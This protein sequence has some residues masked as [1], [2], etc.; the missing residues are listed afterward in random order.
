MLDWA[1][2]ADLDRDY[3]HWTVEI[4]AT[5]AD[6]AGRML[7]SAGS[8]GSADS[9]DFSFSHSLCWAVCCPFSTSSVCSGT[10]F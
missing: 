1:S 8:A 5:A 7:D 2:Q 10:I 3:C 9:G 6:F 4:A